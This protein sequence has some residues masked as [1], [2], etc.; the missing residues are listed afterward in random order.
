PLTTAPL[1]QRIVRGKLTVGEGL[2]VVADL[3]GGQYIRFDRHG[4]KL[5][6]LHPRDDWDYVADPDARGR[7]PK[8]FLV[9][10]RRAFHRRHPGLRWRDARVRSA[11]YDVTVL[12]WYP[13]F[14]R[15]DL[16][17]YYVAIG[18][19]GAWFK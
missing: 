7:I 11:L 15:T 9:N 14:D 12:D 8:S 18:T 6:T 1:A 10:H 17:G 5:G 2:P 3:P 19:S 13:I 4:F 16:D